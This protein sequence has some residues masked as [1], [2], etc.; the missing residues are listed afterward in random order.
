MRRKVEFMGFFF[1]YCFFIWLM[2]SLIFGVNF[3]K[4]NFFAAPWKVLSGVT[5]TTS[6]FLASL[7]VF[8]WKSNHFKELPYPYFISGV[9]IAN[10][11]MLI[12][13]TL[14]AIFTGNI[15]WQFPDFLFIFFSP[16]LLVLMSYLIGVG[17]IVFF[18]SVFSALLLYKI[19]QLID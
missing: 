9:Y 10:L 8:Y 3:L 18:S 4:D 16:F 17:F 19:K 13:F 2:L 12:F 7:L 5:I 15:I 11:S 1:T 14:D 6:G